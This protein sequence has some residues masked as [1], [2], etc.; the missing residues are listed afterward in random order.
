MLDSTWAKQ[1]HQLTEKSCNWSS[2][3]PWGANIKP[4]LGKA[5]SQLSQPINTTLLHPC[6][7]MLAHPVNTVPTDRGML[8]TSWLLFHYRTHTTAVP[9]LWC[10]PLFYLFLHNT[11]ARLNQKLFLSVDAVSFC[12][13][14]MVF[15]KV[16]NMQKSTNRRW[17]ILSTAVFPS[18]LHIRM[19]FFFVLL[20]HCVLKQTRT[21]TG[22]KMQ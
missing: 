9:A 11:P 4:M 15:V 2:P 5:R 12:Q 17:I 3:S 1:T 20:S 10:T 18:G 19:D 16:P 8:Q 21:L 22:L 13:T 6:T 7:A 14:G